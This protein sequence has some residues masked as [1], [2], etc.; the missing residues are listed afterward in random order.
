MNNPQPKCLYGLPTF[1]QSFFYN[2]G[3][4]FTNQCYQ[5]TTFFTV[6]DSVGV[7]S[8]KWNYGD[9]AS[10]PLNYGSGFTS[11][12]IFTS[13]GNYTVTLT[14]YSGGTSGSKTQE[15]QIYSLPVPNLGPDQDLCSNSSVILSPG[16]FSSY[17]WSTNQT[18][19]SIQVST[20]GTFSV[21]VKNIHQC[22]NADT[23]EINLLP[24]PGPPPLIYHD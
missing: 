20:G 23:I 15:V 12:H 10:G 18:T 3:F 19:P 4:T 14:N 22:E 16:N 6:H 9:I 5:D 2:P 17:P 13:P 21:Q 24:S 11:W 1:I 8:C 7:D